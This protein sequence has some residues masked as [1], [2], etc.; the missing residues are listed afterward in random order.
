[1]VIVL[2]FDMHIQAAI[3]FAIVTSF[4][5]PLHDKADVSRYL[6]ILKSTLSKFASIRGFFSEV[7]RCES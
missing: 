4:A 7:E 3:D 1:M 2:V 5:L 6:I